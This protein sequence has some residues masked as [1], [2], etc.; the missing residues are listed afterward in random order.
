MNIYP[1]LQALIDTLAPLG[2]TL[3]YTGQYL[4]GKTNT[5]YKSPC[6]YV[7]MPRDLDVQFYPGR[8]KAAKA[9]IKIHL[10]SPGPYQTHRA[11]AQLEAE[12]SHQTVL[13]EIS[14]LLTGLSIQDNQQ[15]L[16]T[17]QLIPAPETVKTYNNSDIISMVAFNTEI[18][19]Y[20]LAGAIPPAVVVALQPGSTLVQRGVIPSY[21]TAQIAALNLSS[22]PI[23]YVVFNATTK[24][25]IELVDGA[26][27][28]LA[29]TGPQGATGPQGPPGAAGA[30]GPQ[31]LQGIQGPTGAT[32]PQ[33]IPGVDYTV[34]DRR[35]RFTYF[36]DFITPPTA[37]S[38]SDGQALIT[39][40]AGTATV[41]PVAIT[42]ANHINDMR[43]A[44]GGTSTGRATVSSNYTAINLG[45][46]AWEAEL[47]IKIPVLSNPTERFA[48]QFGFLS[49]FAEAAIPNGVGIFYDTGAFTSGLSAVDYWQ[50]MTV[51]SNIRSANTSLTQVAVTTGWT[52]LNI[53]TN[54]AGTAVEFRVDGVLIATHTT[55]IPTAIGREV[56]FGFCITKNVGTTSRYIDVDYLLVEGILNT[57]R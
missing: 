37:T 31:G 11:G 1:V 47:L 13:N 36:N 14:R 57:P 9:N 30:T 40:L 20:V 51:N 3:P 38:G 44:T 28:T 56:G 18:Y 2:P 12:A 25:H 50:T 49:R 32:G 21:T 33:G 35:G 29:S 43:F 17:Q 34:H 46:G 41:A 7:E 45:G 42:G 54:A 10:I 52:K 6:L 16:L 22:L 53:K 23:G 24:Q 8:R 55:N 48:V 39:Q 26:W 19:D 4:P 27:R 15:R 5:S